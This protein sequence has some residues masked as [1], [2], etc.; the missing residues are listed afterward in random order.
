MSK[1]II[2]IAHQKGGVGKSTLALNL[3]Y[4]FQSG[5]Q[6][7]LLDSDLQ[8][9]LYG[10]YALIEGI[11]LISPTKNLAQLKETENDLIIIDTPPY[12]TEQLIE[13]FLISDYILI[14]TKAGFF[15]V[16]ALKSTISLIQEAR[17]RKPELKAGIVLNMVKS[18]TKLTGEIKTMINEMDVKLLDTIITDRVSYTRSVITGGILKTNDEKAKAEMIAV[19][20]EILKEMGL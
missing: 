9:S 3:A 13:L 17:K 6:I 11:N 20:D 16:M 15:D 5:L 10:L 19:S 4:V 1:V 2:T 7:G 18:R 8:G 12:L 14:P